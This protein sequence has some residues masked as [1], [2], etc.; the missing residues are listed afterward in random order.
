MRALKPITPHESSPQGP[1]QCTSRTQKPAGIDSLPMAD[2]HEDM[3]AHGRRRRSRIGVVALAALCAT[4]LALTS[5]SGCRVYVSGSV[6]RNPFV[7][8]WHAEFPLTGGGRLSL[9]YE[10]ERDY[11]YIYIESASG[12]ARVRIEIHG[13]YDYKDGTLILTPNSSRLAPSRLTYEFKSDIELELE[14]QIDEGF[15]VTLT[16]HRHP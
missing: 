2:Q 3:N 5:L 9:E 8:E 12:A 11:S 4:L 16:Y 6:P 13:T 7:G 14:S 10:F 15:T 1:R